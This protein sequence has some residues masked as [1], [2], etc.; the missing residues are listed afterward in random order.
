MNLRE[1]QKAI[2]LLEQRNTH[3]APKQPWT[4]RDGNPIH[5]SMTKGHIIPRLTRVALVG[6]GCLREN[7]APDVWSESL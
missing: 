1:T 5:R 2:H 3:A 4:Q 6:S 7:N